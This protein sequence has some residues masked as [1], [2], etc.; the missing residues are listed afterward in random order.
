[1]SAFSADHNS[2]QTIWAVFLQTETINWVFGKM[3]VWE[4]R[5]RERESCEVNG[6][7]SFSWVICSVQWIA[8]EL[9]FLG[10]LNTGQR[11]KLSQ[12][13]T[14]IATGPCFFCYSQ[15]DLSVPYLWPIIIS[16]APGKHPHTGGDGGD[17]HWCALPSKCHCPNCHCAHRNVYVV[18]PLCWLQLFN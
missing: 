17:A 13:L 18:C 11:N 4:K 7:L 8:F 5:E 3:E 2:G 9:I 6:K 14:A 12:Y 10:A 16:T 15:S 1:M